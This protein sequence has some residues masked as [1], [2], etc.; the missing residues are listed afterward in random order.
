MRTAVDPI[1][2]NESSDDSSELLASLVP[3]STGD[4]WGNCV[5]FRFFLALGK[6]AVPLSSLIGHL[7]SATRCEPFLSDGQAHRRHSPVLLRLPISAWSMPAVLES[8]SLGGSAAFLII[9]SFFLK[10]F[11]EIVVGLIQPVRVLPVALRPAIFL[12]R[13]ESFRNSSHFF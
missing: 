5:A 12:C 11:L 4:C 3:S 7:Q 9:R 6:F 10:C 13:L 2:Y 8:T 1:P